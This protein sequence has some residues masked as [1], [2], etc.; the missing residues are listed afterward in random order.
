LVWDISA[1]ALSPRQ[2]RS[3]AVAASPH[4][5]ANQSGARV[6][7]EPTLAYAAP[8]EIN[9]LT[10]SP[11]LGNMNFGGVPTS[12]GEWIAIAA[13]RTIKALKVSGI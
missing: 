7:T 6:L 10:W 11:P 5:E 4:L 2:H 8:S 1:S 13:G 9:N 3:P 12:G